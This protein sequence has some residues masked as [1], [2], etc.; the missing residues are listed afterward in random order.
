[1]RNA[2]VEL[3]RRELGFPDYVDN[4]ILAGAAVTV[5]K[6]SGAIWAVIAPTDVVYICGPAAAPAVVPTVNVT[7][8]AGMVPVHPRDP[9]ESRRF[10]VQSIASFSMIG[11]AAIVAVMWYGD[12][13]V[14]A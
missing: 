6:P 14:M 12:H 5:T 4:Y 9:I 13:G 10:N 7:N 8:G 1:L 2:P 11:T 3:I